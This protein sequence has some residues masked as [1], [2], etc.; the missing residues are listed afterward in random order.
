MDCL[1]IWSDGKLPF[2]IRPEDLKRDHQSQPRNPIITNVF[3]R[4]GLIEQWGRGTQKIVEL[5]VKAGHPEPEFFEQAGSVVIRF[6]PSG[7]VSP[8]RVAHDLSDRQRQILQ[9]LAKATEL[10][11]AQVKNN[12]TSP[13]ADRTL[14]DDIYHLKRLGMI[15]SKGRGRG[16]RW[17][18]VRQS[19]SSE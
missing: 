8:T 13:P 19:T 5:C 7:Y 10:S 12:I 14:Q 4:R 1:E 11:F 17:Y 6:L 2:D 18:L 16:A 15:S 3:Y 9:V